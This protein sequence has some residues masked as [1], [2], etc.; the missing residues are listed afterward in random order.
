MR[1]FDLVATVVLALIAIVS[2][3]PSGSPT[4]AY[5]CPYADQDSFTIGIH[6]P[7]NGELVCQYPKEVGDTVHVCIYTALTGALSVNSPGTN[8]PQNASQHCEYTRR[9]RF[10]IVD[11]V[12]RR[13]EVR[14]IEPEAV[15]A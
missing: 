7:S 14:S 11:Y 15:A 6:F 1:F 5:I 4:C 8:C 10:N 3:A 12:K 9:K 13:R 2:A